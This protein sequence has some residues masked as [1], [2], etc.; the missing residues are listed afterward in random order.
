MEDFNF[1]QMIDKV[2]LLRLFNKWLTS[3]G[4]LSTDD[5]LKGN[6]TRNG[7]IPERSDISEYMKELYKSSVSLQYF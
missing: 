4:Y 5:Q 2:T 7:K 6:D 1:N 3:F